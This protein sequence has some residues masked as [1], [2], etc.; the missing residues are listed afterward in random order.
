MSFVHLHLHTDGSFLDSGIKPDKLIDRI[1]EMD[2]MPAVAVTDHGT[3][4]SCFDFYSAAVEK[5][6]KP[7][8][9]MEAYLVG[10]VNEKESMKR[11]THITLIATNTDGWRNLLRLHA[12]SY[13]YHFYK[14]P[15][16]DF[17]LLKQH[18]DGLIVLSGCMSGWIN[19]C[20]LNKDM[21]GADT[22]VEYFKSIFG[23]RFYLEVMRIGLE[24][25][26]VLS[27]GI[28]SLSEKHKTK[29]VATNDVHFLKQEHHIIHDMLV[30]V[31]M[32]K[33]FGSDTLTYPE[34]LYLKSANEM[35]KLFSDIPEAVES[36][37]EIADR[38]NLDLSP[39]RSLFPAFPL[40]ADWLEENNHTTATLEDYNTRLQDEY[41]YYLVRLGYKEVLPKEKWKDHIYVKRIKYELESIVRMGYASY[42]IIVA[43]FIKWSIAQDIPISPGR[44]SSAGSLVCF[45][46]GITDLDPIESEL[47]FE[48]FLNPGR[49]GS[50]PDIDTDISKERR[51]EVID[52][53]VEK[54]G[55]ANCALIGTFGGLK[56]KSAIRDFCRVLRI[57]LNITD[58]IA[59]SVPDDP[60]TTFETAMKESP[61]FKKTFEESKEDEKLSLVFVAAQEFE[62]VKRHKS[63]HAAGIVIGPGGEFPI[64]EYVPLF[65][66]RERQ[67][68]FTAVGMGDVEK[69]GLLKMDFLGLETL[70]IIKD[71]C[72]MANMDYYSFRRMIRE[73]GYKD[74]KIID[75]VFKDQNT[76]G[77]FQFEFEG[78]MGYMK[79]LGI[80]EFEDLVVLTAAARPG[81]KDYIS[82]MAECKAGI[83]EPEYDDPRLEPVLK[84]TWGVI[85]YQEQAIELFRVMAGFSLA[86]SDI[87]RRAIGKKK[88]KVMAELKGRFI[89]GSVKNRYSRRCAEQ[90][91]EKIEKHQGYSFNKSH[92]FSYSVVSWM[93]AW[94]KT[95]YPVQFMACVM[96]HQEPKVIRRYVDD[97]R[98]MGIAV[99]PPSV[100]KSKPK[101]VVESLSISVEHNHTYLGYVYENPTNY[102]PFGIRFGTAMIKDV[103]I[104]YDMSANGLYKDPEDFIRKNSDLNSKIIVSL[105]TAGA[106]DCFGIQRDVLLENVDE[107]LASSRKNKT[108]EAQVDLFA[109]AFEDD[110]ASAQLRKP[111]PENQLSI[112][113]IFARES[114]INGYCFVTSF[115]LAFGDEIQNLANG[116]R[117]KDFYYMTGKAECVF[118]GIVYTK[119]CHKS[120][121][122]NGGNLMMF[123]TIG[124]DE[125]QCEVALFGDSLIRTAKEMKDDVSEDLLNEEDV[126]FCNVFAQ[127]N[128]KFVANYL[129]RI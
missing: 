15:C 33:T 121:K 98:H 89:E 29:L 64:G 13:R 111:A 129:R 80:T 113:D 24:E 107:L 37:L 46:L 17:A 109:E 83:R 56:V 125:T 84:R 40:P 91:F 7:I 69:A 18:S 95:Y 54:Y 102:L 38:V 74:Q 1:V 90:V 22:A 116:H 126:V 87:A 27:E 42:F 127:G 61:K 39:K 120:K 62:G 48:R 45:C 5:S 32:G 35:K 59:K 4:S 53:V 58:G 47:I 68:T 51:G 52:Y 108:H 70:D 104:T 124:D 36:T 20:I 44:G 71:T 101:F 96:T 115:G 6:I 9:G 77:V 2:D 119:K 99:L 10:D 88:E 23:D 57:N 63:K 118:V 85:L 60:K 94:L 50:P 128:G 81:A 100:N 55:N 93:C 76:I 112:K 66:D 21:D 72:D 30:C 114:A 28:V 25:D 8:I 122:K 97:C 105:I 41:L 92:A 82:I 117:I 67:L 49:A 79:Q 3:L 26:K 103:P 78:M 75:T 65:F 11:R 106:L 123:L 12:I 19:Q 73:S 31:Q 34:A 86:D 16:I 14:K 43:D 110:D